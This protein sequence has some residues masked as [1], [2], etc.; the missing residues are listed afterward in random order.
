MEHVAARTSHDALVTFPCRKLFEF[1]AYVPSSMSYCPIGARAPAV[2]SASAARVGKTNM[3]A[4]AARRVGFA[5][6]SRG[7]NAAAALAGSRPAAVPVASVVT[8]GAASAWNR[9]AGRRHA[10]IFSKAVAEPDASA[11]DAAPEPIKL[12]TSDESEELLKIRHTTA[13]ICA[14][15]TQKLFPNAQC[16]IGPWYD[17]PVMPVSRPVR[18]LLFIHSAR[19][20]AAARTAERM[21]DTPNPPHPSR[22]DR[23]FY[24][25]FYY[26]E[27]FS[28]A[29]TTP[30]SRV[31]PRA[32]RTRGHPP[33]AAPRSGLDASVPRTPRRDATSSRRADVKKT[34][35]ERA[36]S[37][38]GT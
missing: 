21:A 29:S 38:P 36:A 9:V 33:P 31:T 34:A 15:A 24:Y 4:A 16:T 10:N 23:G 19:D 35:R 12:L 18:S 17:L 8:P 13:H 26:P 30:R 37:R 32:S 7:V 22:I 27:G 2:V 11:A 6:M 5:P 20:V 14:M 1:H 3:M 25:D 28:G